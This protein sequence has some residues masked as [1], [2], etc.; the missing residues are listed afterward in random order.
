MFLPGRGMNTF[1]D[2]DLMGPTHRN[3][4]EEAKAL[5]EGRPEAGPEDEK[6]LWASRC[7]EALRLLQRRDDEVARLPVLCR[8]IFA[9]HAETE[10]G[11]TP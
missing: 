10:K 9:T 11:P 2:T 6:Y 5:W 8:Q 3:W 7:I 1:R 4:L